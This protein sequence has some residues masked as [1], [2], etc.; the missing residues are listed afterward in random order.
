V[1]QVPPSSGNRALTCVQQVGA[2]EAS[3]TPRLHT[4]RPVSRITTWSFSRG[5]EC[6]ASWTAVG[7]VALYLRRRRSFFL[8]FGLGVAQPWRRAAAQGGA[9]GG[10]TP[11][12]QRFLRSCWAGE[13]LWACQKGQ[14]GQK[15][16]RFGQLGAARSRQDE[17]I[18]RRPEEQGTQDAHK[19]KRGD[20]AK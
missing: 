9:Q 19:K 3:K 16:V 11:P 13:G 1:A 6:G 20:A 18:E 12:P 17:L 10:G 5:I 7:A 8:G 4:T 14:M 15:T 2:R